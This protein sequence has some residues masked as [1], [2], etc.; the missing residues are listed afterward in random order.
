MAIIF[1]QEQID[2]LNR[3]AAS[4]RTSIA[5][6]VRRCVQAKMEEISP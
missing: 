1:N 3:A 5:E 4:E 2:F 6:I